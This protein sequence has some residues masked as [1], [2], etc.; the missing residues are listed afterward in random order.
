MIKRIKNLKYK[1][2][3]LLL[4][5]LL[6]IR[7]AYGEEIFFLDFE[8]PGGYTTSIDEFSD[9]A[10]DYFTR[11]DGSD[12]GA[13]SFNNIQ[14]SYYFAAQDIDGEDASL[15]V[16]I[17]IEDVDIENFTSLS[18][19]VYLAEDDNNS[20]ENWD[21]ADYVHIDYDIDGGG[22]TNLLH[23]ESSGGTNTYPAIDDNFDGDGNGDEITDTFT[24]FTASIGGTGSVIDIKITFNLDS[25]DEDIALDNIKITGTPDVEKAT[26]FNINYIT[27]DKT[28]L[29][30][31]EPSGNYDKVVIFG[32]AGGSVTHSPSD[33]GSN[34]NDSDADWDN[35]GI[36]EGDNKLVYAGIAEEVT[37][38]G[39][40]ENT[41]YYFQAYAYDDDKWS[42]GTA[43]IEDVAEVQGIDN[44]NATPQTG[45]ESILLDWDNYSG[46][47]GVWWDEVLILAKKSSAV[48]SAPTGDGS[49]Y[50][51]D[52]DFGAGTE[53]GTG[54]YVVYKGSGTNIEVGN[55]ENGTTYYFRAF[56]RYNSDWTDSDEYQSVF[57]TNYATLSDAN[58][59]IRIT[60]KDSDDLIAGS[61]QCFVVE[62]EFLDKNGDPTGDVST[63][64]NFKAW[65]NPEGTTAGN[66]ILTKTERTTAGTKQ[67]YK[68]K[69]T[70]SEA[71]YLEAYA[72]DID[73]VGQAA[74]NFPAMV[75]AAGPAN[76]HVSLSKDDLTVDE[77]SRMDLT[78]VDEYLNSV[79]DNEE[80]WF[81]TGGRGIVSENTSRTSFSGPLELDENGKGTLYFHPSKYYVGDQTIKVYW[82]GN[83]DGNDDGASANGAVTKEK[84][85]D[86]TAEELGN[87]LLQVIGSAPNLNSN[88][89]DQ[90]VTDTVGTTTKLEVE[91]QDI[92]GNHID[93][94][95]VNDV[96]WSFGDSTVS[97]R[98]SNLKI[99]NNKNISADY[100]PSEKI[101]PVNNIDSVTAY[102]DDG[103]ESTIGITLFSG[104]PYNF[105]VGTDTA[106]KAANDSILIAGNTD[107][108]PDSIIIFDVSDQFGNQVN[109]S[110]EIDYK[111][112]GDGKFSNGQHSIKKRINTG[113]TSGSGIEFYA[114]TIAGE[115]LI[116]AH[117]GNRSDD[118]TIRVLPAVP[119]A[120]YLVPEKISDLI[121]DAYSERLIAE[122][123]DQYG[124][125]TLATDSLFDY[126]P[127]FALADTGNSDFV[128]LGELTERDT[129]AGQYYVRYHASEQGRDSARVVVDI[130]PGATTRKDTT[131]IICIENE[132]FAAFNIDEATEWEVLKAGET[133]KI[134]FTAY[135]SEGYKKYNY[136]DTVQISLLNDQPVNNKIEW[137]EGQAGKLVEI[138]NDSTVT[139]IF[140]EG[141]L[142]IELINKR[143]PSSMKIKLDNQK[144]I[145][146]V[147]D[148]FEYL[149]NIV[150]SLVIDLP[151]QI[152]AD[153]VNIYTVKAVDA[154]GNI[155]NDDYIKFK[156]TARDPDV[157]S[158][159]DNHRFI[160]GSQSYRL[161][162]EKVVEDQWLK[163]YEAMRSTDD[164]DT[165]NYLNGESGVS[166]TF[167]VRVNDTIPPQIIVETP[168]QNEKFSTSEITVSGYLVDE[169]SVSL[170]ID[171]SD[172]EL[173]ET[174]FD[175]IFD[176]GD[177]EGDTSLSFYA[178]DSKENAAV[179]EIAIQ[180]DQSPP[181]ISNFSPQHGDTIRAQETTIS[182][183]V[184]D[185]I[186]GID[187]LSFYFMDNK[188]EV[189]VNEESCCWQTEELETGNYYYAVTV[190]DSVG[191]TAGD[192]I[193]FYLNATQKGDVDL[194]EDINGDD[195]ALVLKH[196]SGNLELTGDA[197]WAADVTGNGFIS[198]LDASY[199]LRY[200]A[201]ETD[202]FKTGTL[203]KENENNV[204]IL[205]SEFKPINK[206]GKGIIPININKQSP[207]YSMEIELVINSSTT[208]FETLDLN[209]PE[210]WHYETVNDQ[211][212]LK[213]VLAGETDFE[214]PENGSLG[215]I[216][217]CKDNNGVASIT[218]Q[219]R[220]NEAK[221]CDI[222]P[223]EI[224]KIPESHK[225][226]PNYPNPFNPETVIHFQIPKQES[227]ELEV[228]NIK[229]EKVAT[230]VNNKVK[231]GDH[232]VT[233][234]MADYEMNNAT[235]I[236]FYRIKAGEFVQIQKMIYLK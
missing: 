103:Y 48:N 232:Y 40:T 165:W 114:G 57:T 162:P 25:G 225:L 180:I 30:W 202:L 228:F 77:Y 37:V 18:F 88:A 219:Y 196:V 16:N 69:Y 208:R 130:G 35:A 87:L 154:Y 155:N 175:T 184:N 66:G 39:L 58:K 142:E 132:K 133:R 203:A 174:A 117:Y 76:I 24:E 148:S 89:I 60:E 9:D 105:S 173:D 150:D 102:T 182:F 223:L 226:F 98:I 42:S 27:S 51:A 135:D 26:N 5:S 231:A 53:L 19:S 124:N 207:V 115:Q 32:R 107:V 1:K 167:D 201:G 138:I 141:D 186:S 123:Y 28:K 72:G 71:I 7:Y 151:D 215:S 119:D 78:V 121:A 118:F 200:W 113:G 153:V 136:N 211:N 192:T 50:T 170:N 108:Y 218:G 79:D 190:S 206:N 44:F 61:D 31:D 140:E 166:T 233:F 56:V 160:Y 120:V 210:S 29:S 6:F 144:G 68:L 176:Y 204:T 221:L 195:A 157:L 185:A 147:T 97:R 85:V 126:I 4:I 96:S 145:S 23:I 191:N 209:L 47:H 74:D 15:P 106:Y 49:A 81:T 104:P 82:D 63:T 169:N 93:A 80:I 168:R 183:Q 70:K 197:C 189:Q 127:E 198:A 156:I 152:F 137:Q 21:P 12:I 205:L 90:N 75:T 220:I 111:T 38:T 41:E 177:F 164:G 188:K 46:D 172:I 13:V 101:R 95:S 161:K 125:L 67:Q 91:F 181:Q 122:V 139:T 178:V 199:I 3:L 216:G 110:Y 128:G 213:I 143:A 212:K 94:Q 236:Y 84:T 235:G 146:L 234:N 129:V 171:G 179:K 34:Y 64:V 83:N 229:G 17:L 230:L 62:T 99:N 224:R 10:Y 149:P 45:Q 227:V 100:R 92:Y 163:Y 214:L 112:D 59:Y 65:L 54:N 8:T 52:A 14:G 11:T 158:V 22:F 73:S 187:T 43:N 134:S 116:S 159:A 55:I 194:N 222:S 20:D 33:V 2:Q 131:T 86:I 36:Y 217:I 193:Q 109:G